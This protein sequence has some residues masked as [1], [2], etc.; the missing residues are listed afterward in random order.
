MN[1]SLRSKLSL[2][3]I[4]MVCLSIVAWSLVASKILWSSYQDSIRR[5][6]QATSSSL[7]SLGIESFSELNDFEQLNLFLEN[8]LQIER[9]DKIVRIYN[10]RQ[11]LIYSSL[12]REQDPF[13][14]KL[15]T[16]Y[17][18]PVFLTLR[19]GERH[20]ESVV[21]P[22]KQK[23]KSFF[24]QVV[25]PLPQYRQIWDNLKIQSISALAVM[26]LI[27]TIFS[28]LFAKRLSQPIQHIAQCLEELDP[29]LIHR[30]KF[31]P[32]G[33]TQQYL[34]PITSSINAMIERTQNAIRRLRKMS[35]YVAHELRTPLTIMR[36]EA[37]LVLQKK[38][39]S[40][41]D[42]Q[43]VLTSSLEEIDRMSDIINTVLQVSEVEYAARAFQSE[44]VH[45]QQ[46]LEQEL[47]L[48]EKLLQRTIPRHYAE[49]E[50]IVL[51]AHPKLLHRLVDNY[52]R[53]IAAH[54]PRATACEL[55]LRCDEQGNLLLTITDHGPGM[56][57]GK[58][59]ALQRG[60][61]TELAGIGLNLCQRVAEILGLELRYCNR[62]GGGF[63]VTVLLPR[64]LLSAAK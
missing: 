44:Q 38:E 6:L 55:E 23:K 30:W 43:A 22:Y 59:Q 42:Y 26:L 31:F 18:H 46:W 4:S 63:Q 49:T 61:T 53:N 3:M 17:E 13:A 5:Q 62:N 24:L 27:A 47:P 39:A 41:E 36:G 37:E 40:K 15:S 57:A 16:K 9:I 25:M 58:L 51:S 7:I 21:V 32:L 14:Q 29:A 52:F 8:A 2:A 60:S 54:T 48:W 10:A 11:E 12:G 64:E 56:D 35:R 19:A 33:P 20:Y 1:S 50:K 45:L 28:F 34:N